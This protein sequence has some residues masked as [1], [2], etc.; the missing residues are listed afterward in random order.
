MPVWTCTDCRKVF[1]GWAGYRALV[2]P[3]LEI[4]PCPDCGGSLVPVEKNRKEGQKKEL[5]YTAA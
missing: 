3:L 2:D 4:P 1:Y 5:D